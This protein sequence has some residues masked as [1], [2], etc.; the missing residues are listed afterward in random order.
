MSKRHIPRS[1]V[2]L[3]LLLSLLV[4][5]CATPPGGSQLR[6]SEAV[7]AVSAT[8]NG[9]SQEEEM[10]LRWEG[11]LP[12]DLPADELQAQPPVMVFPGSGEF[13]RRVT[14]ATPPS[15]RPGDITL[16]FENTDL[17]EVVKV[18][19][20]DLLG[21]NYILDPAVR[22][23]VTMQTSRP[24]NR[25]ALLPTLE[26]LLRMNNSGMVLLEGVYHVMPLAR[27]TKGTSVPQLADAITSLPSGHS[28]QLLPLHYISADEMTKILQ[29]LVNDGSIIRTDTKR[30]LL[31]LSGSARELHHILDIVQLFDVDWISGM[32][33]GFFELQYATTESVQRDLDTILNAGAE[34]DLSSLLRIMPIESINGLL[35]VTPRPHY[36]DEISMWIKR[37]DRI[38]AGEESEPQLFVYRVRNGEA[39]KLAG[40]LSDLF[41]K[42]EKR[43]TTTRASELAPGLTPRTVETRRSGEAGEGEGGTARR[44]QPVSADSATST[45]LEAELRIVA[46]ADNNSLLVMATPRDYQKVLRVLERL[47]V[48][49]LQVHVE[50]TIVEVVLNDE[51]KFGIQWFFD[52]R[53]GNN[54]SSRV[55]WDGSIDGSS[56]GLG[57][58]FPG[59]SWALVNH[60]SEIRAVLNAFAGDSLVN[61]LSAPSVMVLDNHTAKIQVGDQVPIAT[62]SQ[63][64]I[65]G[66]SVINSIQYRNTGILLTVK[67][68]VNPGGLVTMEIDQEVSSVSATASSNLN[69]PTISTRSIS[70]TVA[71]QTGESVV[72]GG[73]IREDNRRTEAGVPGLYHLPFIGKLFGEESRSTNRTEL[74]VI[75]TPRIIGNDRDARRIT[76]DFRARLQ[77]LEGRF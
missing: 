42:D 10:A 53:H 57:R 50:A 70:S 11:T 64:S 12:E 67:P 41:A 31:L 23:G 60:A 6:S 27:I 74:V 30:N 55:G 56:S 38:G 24:L 22:G 25:D 49:P 26:T 2:L 3:S 36:L 32:S 46:D 4:V 33:I 9:P 16:N 75:L 69:S 47:D 18:I 13:V 71:V 65:E 35:V 44:Q 39:E 48:V 62:Q 21:E 1:V 14:P 28:L 59:F 72:L 73:L 17:R 45:N 19:L 15:V 34:T 43:T 54:Y 58:I 77:G 51:L 7:R 40:L 76:E 63:S 68:R 61:V 52:G 66:S 37:L 5:G 20:S 29:P 8:G